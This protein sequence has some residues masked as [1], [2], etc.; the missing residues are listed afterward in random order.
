MNQSSTKDVFEIV[1]NLIIQKLEHGVVPWRQPWA[2]RGPPRNFVTKRAYRGINLLLLNSLCYVRNEFLTFRQVQDLGGQVTKGEK[3][4]LVV[5]WI[6]IKDGKKTKDDTKNRGRPLLRYY[7]VFNISQCTGITDENPISATKENTPLERC[8][9]IVYEMP[10]APKIVHND[11]DAY[12]YPEGDIINL[13]HLEFFESSEAYYGTLF[14]ELIH[15]TGSELRLN[16]KELV[17]QKSFGT[18]LYSIEEL[19]AEI[20][21]CYLCSFAGIAQKGLNNSIAYLQGWLEQLK[22]DKKFIIYAA[23]HAQRATDYILNL[24][25]SEN[26]VTE[27]LKGEAV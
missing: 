13:P 2:K 8:E 23:A 6:W 21:S 26:E 27:H 16:R 5:L 19:T 1:T 22:N 7:Y 9:K 10:D 18:K 24:K 15:A 14:H 17:Q 25:H 20:G 4:H 11:H 3:A 12:Y